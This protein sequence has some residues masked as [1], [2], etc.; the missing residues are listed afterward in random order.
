[1]E[2]SF[3]GK[4]Y[5]W[6]MV[7]FVFIYLM[8]TWGIIFNANSLFLV[9]I[10]QSLAIT[11][12]QTMVA[13][14]FRGIAMTIGAFCAGPL[15]TRFSFLTVNRVAG[16]GLVLFYALTA[17]MQS[18]WQYYALHFLLIFCM[19]ICGLMAGAM[20]IKEWFHTKTG[21]AMGIALMG[22]SAGGT[23]FSALAGALI[24]MVGW[25]NTIS[26]FAAQMLFI[27]LLA[28]FKL[29]IP[30]PQTIGLRPY[31]N[32]VPVNDDPQVIQPEPTQIARILF[33]FLSLGILLSNTAMNILQTNLPPHL[34]SVG[35]AIGTQSLVMSLMM[36]S[37]ALSKILLGHLYDAFGMRTASLLTAIGLLI[38]YVGLLF[39]QVPGALYFAA[40]GLGFGSAFNSLGP[41]IFAQA[42][43]GA[44]NFTKLN[45]MFQSISG[46]GFVLGPIIVATLFGIFGNYWFIFKAFSVICVGICLIWIF[47]LPSKKRQPKKLGA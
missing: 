26:I 18:V 20:L 21:F 4:H 35:I 27:V 7:A 11:R 25:R 13:N 15:Y 1:M 16:L 22:S 33:F 9:P 36:L 23:L 46:F 34:E 19:T 17:F 47:G 44:S 29:Y 10:E 31:G 28:H 12:E 40:V 6:A 30:T 2:K 38:G 39:P 24:P 37:M 5:G 45:S 43:S 32:A 41:P 42:L 3:F 14:M 8:S